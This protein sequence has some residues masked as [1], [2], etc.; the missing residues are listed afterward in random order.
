MANHAVNS[1]THPQADR[2]LDLY[3]TPPGA[4]RALLR[5]ERLPHGIW[6]PAAGRGAIVNVLR[7]SGH[8]VIA[9]DIFDYGFPLH[10]VGDF[11]EQTETPK[12]CGCLLTNPPYRIINKFIERALDLSPMV[13]MLA[14]LALLESG[15]RTE[16][17]E[18]RGLARVYV[19]RDRL[20]MMHR[21][22]WAGPRSTSATAFAWFLWDRVHRGPATFH[23]ISFNESTRSPSSRTSLARQKSGAVDVTPQ[24]RFT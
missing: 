19:F 16:I 3:E 10:F 11:L 18:R 20:P 5:A 13:V 9:S 15:G 23:R 12:G 17:L 1:G 21:D 24:R 7:D 14:R 8:A 2:G 6:E 4:V 22:G